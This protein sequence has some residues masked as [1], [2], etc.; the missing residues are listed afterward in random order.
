VGFCR[1][2]ES[3]ATFDTAPGVATL[4]AAGLAGPDSLTFEPVT[5]VW[6]SDSKSC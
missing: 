2:P 3:D 1:A 5:L 6:L 4:G